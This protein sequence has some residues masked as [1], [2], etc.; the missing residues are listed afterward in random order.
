MGGGG[1]SEKME[2]SISVPPV[3]WAPKSNENSVKHFKEK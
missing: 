2:K 1:G 3:Y